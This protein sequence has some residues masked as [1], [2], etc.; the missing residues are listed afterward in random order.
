MPA[1]SSPLTVSHSLRLCLLLLLL[2]L[3][4][5]AMKAAANRP[6]TLGVVKEIPE[7]APGCL[8]GQTFVISGVL[9]SLE[10]EA[11]KTL[12]ERYGGRVTGSVSGKTS[13]LLLGQ[14]GG[15]SKRKQAEKL[16][17]KVIDEDGLFD[18]IRSR[19]GHALG[20]EAADTGKAATAK[21]KKAQSSAQTA[22][23]GVTAS[24]NAS[25]SKGREQLRVHGKT[26]ARAED[27]LWVDKHRPLRLADIIGNAS[28]VSRL[29][30][31]LKSWDATFRNQGK[32]QKGSFKAA[33]ITG[34]P[35]IGKST[36]A[37]LVA[38]SAQGSC[39]TWSAPR[40]LC[41]HPSSAVC[42]LRLPLVQ[43]ERLQRDRAER[44]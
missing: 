24:V 43:G 21:A 15:E 4:S 34:A 17:T 44:V 30:G 5:L 3:L 38:R 33:L 19:K 41:A 26:A 40:S 1:R 35:G 25:T 11:A 14:E 36:S 6:L 29:A 22:A 42:C 37:A 23:Q 16:G 32:P 31:W 18:L 8:Q 28:C 20:A 13:F 39:C 10:R 7:G 27:M 12:I 9:D 2:P